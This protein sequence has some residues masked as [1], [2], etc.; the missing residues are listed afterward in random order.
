MATLPSSTRS[1]PRLPSSGR[2]R[3]R[4][5]SRRGLWMQKTRR[6]R[7]MRRSSRCSAGWATRA[8]TATAASA[9]R[10]RPLCARLSPHAWRGL[11]SS[12]PRRRLC[13]CIVVRCSPPAR[14]AAPRA[15][16]S[17]TRRAARAVA[18]AQAG[19]GPAAAPVASRALP[20]CAARGTSSSRSALRQRRSPR[21]SRR[22]ARARATR[23]AHPA[24][25]PQGGVPGAVG[26][27]VRAS[28]LPFP[29]GP[30]LCRDRARG[31]RVRPAA[32]GCAARPPS[33][34]Q[35]QASGALSRRALVDSG[36]LLSAAGSAALQLGAAPS[37]P[38]PAPSA[39]AAA[40]FAAR[41][42]RVDGIGREAGG[43]TA[44]SPLR[45]R[46]AC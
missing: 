34:P 11:P 12:P 42:R 21:R 25:L 30:Q 32:R 31:W 16:P 4:Q 28:S 5:R 41:A 7:L 10:R 43:G 39:D 29:L 3:A 2:R 14:R 24:A 13:P 35:V 23:R 1:R 19:Q 37:A 38:P 40:P 6:S 20:R 27:H 15:H 8:A 17:E 45:L 44:H 33:S 36:T 26:G 22:W 18:T 46:G 9:P